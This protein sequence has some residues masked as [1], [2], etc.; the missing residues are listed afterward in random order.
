MNK[1]V[2]WVRPA[3]LFVLCVCLATAA[4]GAYFASQLTPPDKAEQ[5]FPDNHM[6][7]E[8]GSFM[9]DNFYS[10]DTAQYA[11]LEFFWGIEGSD[12]SDFNVYHPDEGGKVAKF[13]SSFDLSTPEAQAAMLDTCQ[14]LRTLECDRDGCDNKGY[15]KRTLMMQTEEKSISCFLEDFKDWNKGVLPVGDAFLPLL[16]QFR[17]ENPP[18][19]G[20]EVLESNYLHDIGIISGSLKYATIRIRSTI[21]SDLP[22]NK[23]IA[24]R[25]VVADFVERIKGDMPKDMKSFKY[26]ADGLFAGYDLGEELL[27]G[28]FSGCA[29]AGPIAFLVLLLSTK[30]IITSLY[31]VFCVGSIVACVLGFCKS[32]MGWSLGI[33]EAIAGVIV[34]GY[35]VDYVVHLAHMYCEGGHHGNITRESRC[36]FAISNMGSTVFAGAV[37][38]AASAVIMFICFLY[39]FV[40]MAILICIT[41]MYSFIFSLGLFMALMWTAGPEGN[42]GDLTQIGASCAK[43]TPTDVAEPTQATVTPPKVLLGSGATENE[44]AEKGEGA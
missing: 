41:I 28:F 31:A 3:P 14:K 35:S 21:R 5:W 19:Y 12:L 13:D 27:S 37:T 17:T 30:N 44:D 38:T 25:K 4:Q 43:V 2:G 29:I 26:H 39:F 24:V 8:L 36:I 1:K 9:G 32:A 22:H 6:L 10:P 34:I 23:G 15:N 42:M 16:K 20:S 11:V 7:I 33:G 40:K 18:G